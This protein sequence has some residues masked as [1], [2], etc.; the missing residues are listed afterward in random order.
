[1]FELV[2]VSA[3]ALIALVI[4]LWG[5]AYIVQIGF[6]QLIIG[7]IVLSF[8]LSLSLSSVANVILTSMGG[9]TKEYSQNNQVRDESLSYYL[10]VFTQCAL[11][12]FA[13]PTLSGILMLA[14]LIFLAMAA[15]QLTDLIEEI[16]ILTDCHTAFADRPQKDFEALSQNT[17]LK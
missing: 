12:A 15:S 14:I 2:F 10:L 3:I 13:Q 5:A 17:E 11:A 8:F 6:L 7:A 9:L 1:M 4:A 16:Q